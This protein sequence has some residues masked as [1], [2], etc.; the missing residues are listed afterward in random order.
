MRD[1]GQAGSHL[2]LV[3]D[4]LGEKAAAFDV[5]SRV[6]PLQQRL[7]D[8]RPDDLPAQYALIDTLARMGVLQPGPASPSASA[9]GGVTPSRLQMA[10]AR[11]RQ[12]QE[13]APFSPMLGGPEWHGLF[14]ASAALAGVLTLLLGWLLLWR[15]RRRVA[16]LMMT[17]SSRRA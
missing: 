6:A 12:L 11:Y 15:Y 8:S 10:V 14:V 17:A 7:A 16:Q 5:L 2:G 13:H 3:L 4:D 1:L 9:P